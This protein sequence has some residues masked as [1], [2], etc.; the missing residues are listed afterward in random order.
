MAASGGGMEGAKKRLWKEK[1]H[2]VQKTPGV[3]GQDE[4]EDAG[5]KK[6]GV[7]EGGEGLK[8]PGRYLIN[9]TIAP[10]RGEHSEKPL[11]DQRERENSS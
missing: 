9:Q 2:F 1:E 10:L 6:R 8:A 7:G 5:E 4:G 11:E 3:I